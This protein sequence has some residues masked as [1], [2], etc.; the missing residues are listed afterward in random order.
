MYANYHED[1][2]VTSSKR[3]F[4]HQ[5]DQQ[6]GLSKNLDFLKSGEFFCI[7][8]QISSFEVLTLYLRGRKEQLER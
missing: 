6:K 1:E 8:T 4:T 3:P 7:S 2:S 5:Y